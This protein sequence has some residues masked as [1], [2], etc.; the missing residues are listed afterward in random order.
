MS[1]PAQVSTTL[2]SDLAAANC[3]L[4]SQAKAGAGEQEGEQGKGRAWRRLTEG[5]V[6]EGESVKEADRTDKSRDR[7]SDL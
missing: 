5:D 7:T 4:M 1:H 3:E 6:T 2:P